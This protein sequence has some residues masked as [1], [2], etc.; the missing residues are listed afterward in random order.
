MATQL[1]DDDDNEH[2]DDEDEKLIL[3]VAKQSERWFQKLIFV[4]AK[5]KTGPA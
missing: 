4:E 1:H 5:K 2:N 3:I